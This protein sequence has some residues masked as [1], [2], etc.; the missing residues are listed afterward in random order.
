MSTVENPPFHQDLREWG[1]FHN[2]TNTPEHLH[3]CAQLCNTVMLWL[4][5]GE[6][7]VATAVGTLPAAEVTFGQVSLQTTP[8]Y[9]Q[10][11]TWWDTEGLNVYVSVFR[12]SFK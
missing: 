1:H 11:T 9:L 6:E 4:V 12:N 3:F 8:L 2:H 7:G 10:G 5:N